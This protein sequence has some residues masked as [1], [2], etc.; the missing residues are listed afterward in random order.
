MKE[1]KEP[2]NISLLSLVLLISRNSH[3]LSTLLF[4]EIKVRR[5]PEWDIF[6]FW[7]PI[8]LIVLIW[9][10][11]DRHQGNTYQ[12]R[13]NINRSINRHIPKCSRR[14]LWCSSSSQEGSHSCSNINS[15]KS[16]L[17]NHCPL[18]YVSGVT[19]T[20]S[21]MKSCTNC[22]LLICF[23]KFASSL[24]ARWGMVKKRGREYLTSGWD[25]NQHTHPM[26]KCQDWVPALV[27]F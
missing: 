26:S 4:G 2:Q 23:V 21:I 20:E 7:V 1:I 13:L 17:R 5:W 24:Q 15:M 6:L 22:P 19:S 3:P 16:V 27:W 11:N 8:L 10:W 14:L 9:E 18:L 12:S 25:A